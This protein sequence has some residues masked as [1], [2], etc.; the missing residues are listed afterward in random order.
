M[1][2]QHLG[3]LVALSCTSACSISFKLID[4]GVPIFL[5][6]LTASHV[7]KAL[8]ARTSEAWDA[9][10]IYIGAIRRLELGAR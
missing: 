9:L 7:L 1:L 3:L 2:Q 5:T 6:L 8:W 10:S 4:N